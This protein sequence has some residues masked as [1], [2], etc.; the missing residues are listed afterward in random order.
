MYYY[1]KKHIAV[2][3]TTYGSEFISYFTWVDQIINLQDTI[4]CIAV[5]IHQN[6][7]IFGD[8]KYFVHSG[9]HPHT[10]LRKQDT[11]LYFN[12]DWEA[13]EYNMAAFYHVSGG[14]KPYD[15]L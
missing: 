12:W 14:D 1:S 10:K 3:T 6:I 5:P 2:E 15:I 8:N 9:M 11:A 7:Y 4:W 13:I